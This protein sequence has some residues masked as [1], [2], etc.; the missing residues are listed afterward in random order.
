MSNLHILKI[1]KLRNPRVVAG[2]SGWANAGEVS[3]GIVSYLKS[4]LKPVK[5]AELDPDPFYDFTS[6]RPVASITDGVIRRF[7]FVSNEF[8]YWE[9]P[10]GQKDLILFLGA[11]P[12]LRWREYTEAF[13]SAF[14]DLDPAELILLGSFYDSTPH[15]RPPQVSAALTD[16]GMRATLEE[17]DLQFTDYQGPTSIHSMLE[18]TAQEM[19]LP[20]ISLWSGTPHYLP[21]ANPKAWLAVLERLLPMLGIQLDLQDLERKGER[22]VQ[23]VNQ[24]LVQNPKLRQYVRQL[25]RAIEAQEEQEPLRSDE[26]IKSLE[27]FLKRKQREDS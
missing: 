9:D 20:S 22:L 7:K 13:F 17:Y 3:T 12:H 14:Q 18:H 6:A 27:E 2:F 16:S 21:T 10:E 1:P 19:G 15:S 26:I 4:K 25:E 5:Y 24:A 8:Y 23:Q 11:E